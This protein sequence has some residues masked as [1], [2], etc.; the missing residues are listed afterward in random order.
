MQSAK[1]L[2]RLG[3]CPGHWRKKILNI[4]SGVWGWGEAHRITA[5]PL[6]GQRSLSKLLGCLPTVPIPM[7]DYN[8]HRRGANICTFS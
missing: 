4:G 1:K 6:V 3:G 5:G 8:M 2:I 7:H